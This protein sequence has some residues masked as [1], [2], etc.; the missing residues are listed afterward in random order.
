MMATLLGMTSFIIIANQVAEFQLLSWKL[1]ILAEVTIITTFY[2]IGPWLIL[3]CCESLIERLIVKGV[4]LSL[5]S[6]LSTP[7][8]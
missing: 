6:F 1:P 2:E 7:C 3:L 4:V 8:Q 5:T